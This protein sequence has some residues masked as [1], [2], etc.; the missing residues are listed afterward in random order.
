MKHANI[1]IFIPHL[2]CPNDCVFCNQKTISGHGAYCYQTVEDEITRALATLSLGTE[3]EIAYF[4][5]SFTAIGETEMTALLEIA[6]RFC[7]EGEMDHVCHAKPADDIYRT[8]CA[9]DAH[10]AEHAGNVL[11][12]AQVTNICGASHISDTNHADCVSGI[13][14]V[15]RVSG[16]RLSTRPDCVEQP[17]LD[18]LAR[19]PV[20]T[21]E[22]GI[23]SFSDRVLEQSGRGHS[24][25][26]AVSACRR[27]KAAG[28]SLVGQ[29]MIGLPASTAEDE[30]ET[31]RRIVALG[32]DGARIYPTVVFRN[33]RL[34]DMVRDGSYCPLSREEAVERTAAVLDVFDRAHIPVLRIGLCANEGLTGPDTVAAGDYHPAFGELAGGRLYLHRLREALQTFDEMPTSIT[35]HCRPGGTSMLIGQKRCNAAVLQNEYN[36]KKIKVIENMEMIGYNIKVYRS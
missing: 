25:A 17:I 13:R 19:Y 11:H 24:A 1:P 6:A 34:F 10:C 15:G 7:E 28:F 27:V 4:G 35:V 12:A 32:A 5:G 9:G 23:Q 18:L 29:M 33:T 16:I 26:C 3:A 36:V 2:G 21:I 14:H 30:M 20:H 31:A 8:E 22:L